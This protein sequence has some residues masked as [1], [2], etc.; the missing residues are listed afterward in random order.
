MFV[1]NAGK[2]Y[3][4]H[5]CYSEHL[6]ME[7]HTLKNSNNCL[8]TNLYCYLET[9]GDQSYN[10]SLNVVHFFNASFNWTSVAT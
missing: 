10:L 2:S 8:N 6:L 9:S 4:G 5:H 1:T 3:K 7:Q